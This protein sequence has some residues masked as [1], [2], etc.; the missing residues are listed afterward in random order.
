MDMRNKAKHSRD[1]LPVGTIRIRTRKAG[2][3]RNRVRYIKVRNSGPYKDR[4]TEYARWLWEQKNGPVPAGKRVAH[5]DGDT[6]NDSLDNLGPLSP[7]DIAFL[8]HDRDPAGSKRNYAKCRAATI[9]M[10]RERGQARRVLEWL[11]ARWYPVD[12][13]NRRVLNLPRRMRWQVYSALGLPISEM[14]W[15]QHRSIALGWSMLSGLAA[16]I[17]AVLVEAEAAAVDRK[18]LHQRTK[19]L[20]T[21]RG[22]PTFAPH[23]FT[24][25][26]SELRGNGLLRKVESRYLASA[27]AHET[28][29]PVCPYALMRGRDV[30]RLEGYS[31]LHV[32]ECRECRCTEFNCE[33][34]VERTGAPCWWAGDDLC[35]AC[36]SL[37]GGVSA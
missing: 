30:A 17:L 26:L 1:P 10:N 3:H 34:C 19:E 16:C 13:A 9:V 11:P 23:R 25:A 32:P 24:C 5:L 36:A 33:Q 15:R 21:S 22:W 28:R 35:S 2:R 27:A 37:A 4:W 12:H 31:K 14:D 29:G 7:G 18:K 6:L 8:W 20:A